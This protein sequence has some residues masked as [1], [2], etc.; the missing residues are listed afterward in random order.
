MTSSCSSL[1]T[2]ATKT[3][4]ASTGSSRAAQEARPRRRS[5]ARWSWPA[6][7][8]AL[9]ALVA[10][11]A[12]PAEEAAGQAEASE[13]E[14]PATELHRAERRRAAPADPVAHRRVPRKR[15]EAPPRALAGQ[16]A[17]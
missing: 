6:D 15:R 17:A 13:A 16:R 5:P 1:I 2:P 10:W 7:P 3:A 11:K 9:V 4:T 12:A 8:V 14:A